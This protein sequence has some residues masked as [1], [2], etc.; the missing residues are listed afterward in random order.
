MG[1]KFAFDNAR[2]LAFADGLKPVH[3][4]IISDELLTV[5]TVDGHIT[6][7]LNDSISDRDDL[8]RPTSCPGKKQSSNVAIMVRALPNYLL[9]NPQQSRH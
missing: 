5:Y 9:R 1:F 2:G 3:T 8:S 7:S 6:E 4:L